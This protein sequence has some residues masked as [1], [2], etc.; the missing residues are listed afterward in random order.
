MVLGRPLFASPPEARENPGRIAAEPDVAQQEAAEGGESGAST[1][2]KRVANLPRHF[3]S[4]TS[5]ASV[6]EADGGGGA[7]F[8]ATVNDVDATAAG[9][10]TVDAD[11]TAGVEEDYAADGDI[12]VALGDGGGCGGNGDR[13]DDVAIFEGPVDQVCVCVCVA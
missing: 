2:S 1:R 8:D 11:A 10:A 9:N 13:P 7:T 4:G 12:D 3:S 6:S 5:G